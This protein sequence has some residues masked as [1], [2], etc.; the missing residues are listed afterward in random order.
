M[1]CFSGPGAA[2]VVA[3]TSRRR[4][5]LAPEDS[6]AA[7]LSDLELGGLVLRVHSHRSSRRRTAESAPTCPAGHNSRR[8]TAGD[9]PGHSR[10]RSA[11][12]RIGH[13]GHRS[14]GTVAAVL[15]ADV[16]GRSIAAAVAVAGGCCIAVVGTPWR[17]CRLFSCSATDAPNPKASDGWRPLRKC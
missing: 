2:L 10:N 7:E 1:A 17:R 11:A 16:L 15:A 5:A 4:L 8:S 13:T 14:P 12:G 6:F 9:H 3:G